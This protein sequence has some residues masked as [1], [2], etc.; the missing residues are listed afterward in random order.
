MRTRDGRLHELDVLVVATGFRTDRFMR[1]TQVI[2]RDGR[3][4]DDEWVQRPSSYLTVAIPGFP[5]LFLLNGPNSPVGNFPLI[6]VAEVQMRYILQL[7]ELLR[8]GRCREISASASAT[9]TSR[10]SAR[11]P[12][13]TQFG[14]PAARAG[15]STIEGFPPP[16]RGPSRGFGSSLRPQS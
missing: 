10:R 6:E 3:K 7:F 13:R 12:R 5:N 15:I 2:G 14:R 4:L 9:M 8:T 1:P 11:A 16:G